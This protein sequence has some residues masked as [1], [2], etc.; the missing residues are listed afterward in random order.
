[1]KK[2]V[3]KPE[4]LKEPEILYDGWE[5]GIRIIILSLGTHPCAYVGIPESHPVAGWDYEAL[6]FVECH[7]G[8]TY[9]EKGDDDYLP[10]GCW[11]YGWDYAHAGDWMGYYTEED[12]KGAF[13]D[14]KKWTTEEIYQEARW[15][16]YQM[17][18]VMNWVEEIV[19]KECLKWGGKNGKT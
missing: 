12:K 8:F 4:R 18:K 10:A 13:R 17:R 2:M 9:S 6:S 7:G 11:W 3:Y 5:E 19:K 16:A 15:V 1:M 14:Y